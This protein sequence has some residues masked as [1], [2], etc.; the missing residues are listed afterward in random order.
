MPRPAP[1]TRSRL[2]AAA[3]AEFAARGYAGANVDRIAR[4]A[5]VN[6]AMIYYHFRSKAALY[7][8]I[9]RDMFD[10]VAAGVQAVAAST[11]P[12]DEKIRRF[13]EAIVSAAEER[14]HFPAIWLRELAEGAAHTDAATLRHAGAVLAALGTILEEGR[15]LRRFQPANPLLVHIGI[16]APLL[17]FL[18]SAPL[19]RKLDRIATANA[20][21]VSR[22]AFV[23]HIQRVTLAV[24]EGRIA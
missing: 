19:R 4:A 20:A 6:K 18:A 14:P 11:R 8:E 15:R 12:P 2:L 17:L 13:V 7:G 5:R 24:L 9:L 21:V 1:D 22:D 23:A 10:A 16:V 3:A